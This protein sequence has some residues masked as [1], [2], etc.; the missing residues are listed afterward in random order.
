MS[1]SH[2]NGFRR[3]ITQ[4]QYDEMV[5]I[6]SDVEDQA[7]AVAADRELAEEARDAAET[8][9]PAY[10]K[11]MDALLAATTVW[12]VGTRLNARTGEVLDV[13][14]AG[15][16]DYDHPVSGIG[17]DVVTRNVPTAWRAVVD[18]IADDAVALN[19][20][21]YGQERR[22]A[23]ASG[24]VTVR[25]NSVL[26]DID[27]STASGGD[28]IR[29]ADDTED[30][31][32]DGVR[33]NWTSGP[34]GFQI[35][36]PNVKRVRIRDS[37]FT[38]TGY[39]FLINQNAADIDQVW[40]S[41]SIFY[42]PGGGDGVAINLPGV[43]G[44]NFILSGLAVGSNPAGSNTS[45]N[46]G[47]AVSIANAKGWLLSTT[48]IT[49]SRLEA[50]HIEDGQQNGVVTGVFARNLRRQAL[51]H[52]GPSSAQGESDPVMVAGYS[53]RKRVS[54]YGTDAMTHL[55]VNGTTYPTPRG[56]VFTSMFSRGFSAA[57][58]VD[59]YGSSHWTG[60][61]AQ[62]NFAAYVGEFARA[63][64]EITLLDDM[65]SGAAFRTG[66]GAIITADLH[67]HG[68]VPAIISNTVGSGS[69]A[70]YRG[71]FTK[72]GKY[73]SPAVGDIWQT[74]CGIPQRLAAHVVVVAQSS[75]GSA[76]AAF[77]VVWDGTTLTS[78]RVV[79]IASGNGAD[80]RLRVQSGNLQFGIYSGGSFSQLNYSVVIDGTI[81]QLATVS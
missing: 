59:E 66:R 43:T 52:Y 58:S 10:Y 71:K 19:A 63:S 25:S 34:V 77:D 40:L 36:A 50:I 38:G 33:A 67:A 31:I 39:P 26:E 56:D 54:D 23:F 62:A 45:T 57:L 64:G 17:L 14:A 46:N 51:R 44:E 74:I 79:Q 28:Q 27:L 49:G 5:G 60:S 69:P 29:F 6:L 3:T 55:I 2:G 76:S 35:N 53:A 41:D 4:E 30:A 75:G 24:G 65:P 32:I 11:D 68:N 47:F 61:A 21:L 22:Q 37:E 73:S 12:P 80:C 20:W 70:I 16:G 15:T 48:A 9:A 81:L 1:V 18:G 7:D 8:Y 13:V 72:T 42:S 78:T